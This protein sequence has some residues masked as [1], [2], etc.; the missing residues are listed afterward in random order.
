MPAAPSATELR[1]VPR[2]PGGFVLHCLRH[3]YGTRLG[4]AGAGAFTIMRLMGHSSETV[5]QRYVHLERAI[6]KL[7]ALKQGTPI[8]LPEGRNGPLLLQISLQGN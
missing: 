4:E 1:Q 3:T 5:P 6:E 2:L 7:E 8:R